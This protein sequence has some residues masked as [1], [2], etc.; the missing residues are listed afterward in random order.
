MQDLFF[1][2][3]KIFWLLLSPDNLFLLLLV[4]SLIALILNRLALARVLLTIATTAVL[5]LSFFKVGDLML[6]P[7]ESKTLISGSIALSS[8]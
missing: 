1:Y 3:S 5:I 8:S 2:S 4:S 7:L 6:Y